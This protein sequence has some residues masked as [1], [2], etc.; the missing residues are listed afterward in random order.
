MLDDIL[1]LFLTKGTDW[2]YEKEWRII[3][4]K[5]QMYDYN[6]SCLYGGNL[7]FKCITGIYLGYRIHPEVKKNIKEICE[8]IS[9]NSKVVSL[10]QAH[11]SSNTYSIEFEKIK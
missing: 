8:R 6:D 5:K 3:F 1:P 7:L 2:E 9:S 4:T 11:L 10:Y